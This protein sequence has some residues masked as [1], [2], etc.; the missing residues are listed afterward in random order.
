MVKWHSA[1]NEGCNIQIPGV[2]FK[3]VTEYLLRKLS[4]DTKFVITSKV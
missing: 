3:R 4:T 2:I 1:K